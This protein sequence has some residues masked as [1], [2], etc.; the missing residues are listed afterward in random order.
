[1]PVHLGSMSQ[2]VV[3]MDAY[4][5]AGPGASDGL[6]EGDVLVSNHPQLAGGSHL[7]DLTVVTPVFKDGKVLVPVV[8]PCDFPSGNFGRVPTT[9]Q[10]CHKPCGATLAL[11]KC[12]L[13]CCARPTRQKVFYVASRAHHA[14]IGGIAPGS[15][16]PN[17]K[18]LDEEGAAIVAFKLVRNGV[19]QARFNA[20]VSWFWREATPPLPASEAG[21]LLWPQEE[22]ITELLMAPGKSGIPGNSGTRNLED[23]ISDLKAQVGSVTSPVA[24]RMVGAHLPTTCHVDCGRV[25][26]KGVGSAGFLLFHVRHL[27]TLSSAALRWQQ[28]TKES[29]LSAT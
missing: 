13:A 3:S 9:A 23:N 1:M 18:R 12:A 6:R 16:P 20:R 10:G 8:L 19:F 11:P 5:T 2:T 22:G 14:D 29:S 4:Y 7:P 26:S 25:T 21:F 24:M 28:T 15:M 27:L 17:S